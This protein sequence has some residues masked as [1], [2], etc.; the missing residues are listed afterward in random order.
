MHS[1]RVHYDFVT[2]LTEVIATDEFERKVTQWQRCLTRLTYKK[3]RKKKRISKFASPVL[4]GPAARNPEGNN[5]V[6]E[7]AL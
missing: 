5:S 2:Q 1:S 6:E 4:T 7:A 3:K